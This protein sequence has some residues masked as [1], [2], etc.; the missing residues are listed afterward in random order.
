MLLLSISTQDCVRMYNERLAHIALY[1]CN[2][3][4][5]PGTPSKVAVRSIITAIAQYRG[6][7][8]L[9]FVHDSDT[10]WHPGIQLLLHLFVGLISCCL[11]LLSR[12]SAGTHFSSPLFA[13]GTVKMVALSSNCLSSLFRAHLLERIPLRWQ[14]YALEDPRR[15]Y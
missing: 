9:L 6:L 8:V 10:S 1:P 11:V 2:I 7:F 4:S 14:L 3:T 13:K 5:Q 12:M 15:T